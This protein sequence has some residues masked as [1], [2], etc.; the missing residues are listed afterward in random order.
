MQD[1]P[2]LPRAFKHARIKTMAD[3]NGSLSTRRMPS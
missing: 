2:F 1:M 3:Y